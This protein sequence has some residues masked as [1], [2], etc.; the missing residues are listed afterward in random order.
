MDD[1]FYYDWINSENKGKKKTFTSG[2]NVPIRH[3]DV[4]HCHMEI[5]KS[6]LAK[7]KKKK[8]VMASEIEPN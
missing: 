6:N 3:D 5:L 7:K 2:I 1:L 4:S 8:I